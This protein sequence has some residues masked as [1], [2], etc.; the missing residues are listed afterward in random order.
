MLS[1]PPPV[2]GEKLV[3]GVPWRY[4]DPS[5]F[6][7]FG[8]ELGVG[9]RAKVLLATKKKKRQGGRA[10]EAG[11]PHK[12]QGRAKGFWLDCGRGRPGSLPGSERLLEGH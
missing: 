2:F 3:A 12:K 8:R 9:S 7:D 6:F 1:P 11:K 10:G 5:S 4:G